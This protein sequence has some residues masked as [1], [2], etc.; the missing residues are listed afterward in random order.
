MNNYGF[1]GIVGA[2]KSRSQERKSHVRHSITDGERIDSAMVFVQGVETLLFCCEESEGS[3][4]SEESEGSEGSEDW[5]YDRK[6]SPFFMV[7]AVFAPFVLSGKELWLPNG[8]I[9]CQWPHWAQQ[10]GEM[11]HRRA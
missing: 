6:L 5:A 2:I 8:M 10:D 1:C 7:F 3:E 11:P 4:E 9:R